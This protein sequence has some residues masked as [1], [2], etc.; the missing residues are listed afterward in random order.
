MSLPSIERSLHASATQLQWTVDAYTLTFASLLLVA[1]NLGD[2][3]GRRG[4][5][6]V[7]LLIFGVGSGFAAFATSAA[8]L[9]AFRA[10]MGAAGAAIFP[11]TLS[12]VTN[13]FE[14]DERGRAIG[15]WSA[16]SGLGIAAGPIVGGLL[17]D[18]FWW[19]SVLLVN[20][21]I[22]AVSLVLVALFVPT[23]KDEH[24]PPLDIPG[25]VLATA[26]M[27][28]LIYGIIEAPTKGWGSTEVL[29]A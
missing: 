23:S 5:L 22:V 29:V 24:A 10:L 14:G 3:Y 13:I 7:G 6:L 1:G 17:L 20:V 21:P 27:T 25:A 16:L 12:I 26:G 19:G 15:I 4:A 8:A 2:K 28:A 11:T 9:I 18:H